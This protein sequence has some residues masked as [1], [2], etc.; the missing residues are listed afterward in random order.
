MLNVHRMCCDWLATDRRPFSYGKKFA[1]VAVVAIKI[2]RQEVAIKINHHDV[3][4][5]GRAQALWNRGFTVINPYHTIYSYEL[6]SS[7]IVIQLSISLV[8]VSITNSRKCCFFRFYI[9]GRHVV[10]SLR[11]LNTS[12]EVC[13]S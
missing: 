5:R 8:K 1:M 10:S 11:F 7:P 9:F 13:D 4:P 6:H 3:S 2:S 12:C